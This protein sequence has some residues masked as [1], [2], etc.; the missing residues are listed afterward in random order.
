MSQVGIHKINSSMIKQISYFSNQDLLVEFNN[1]SI[2]KYSNVP[3]TVYEDLIDAE[4]DDEKSF[5]KVFNKIVKT[6]EHK[7]KKLEI[8]KDKK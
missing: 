3:N 7:Y 8:D 2:Y 1:G 5:G 4:N 6:E